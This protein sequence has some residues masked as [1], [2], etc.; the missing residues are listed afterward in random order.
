MSWCLAAPICVWA[1]VCVADALQR[2]NTY[3]LT[4]TLSDRL[5]VTFLAIDNLTYLFGPAA[6]SLAF[7][8]L[9]RP[10]ADTGIGKASTLLEKEGD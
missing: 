9:S 2:H 7:F 1:F 6:S 8:L 5:L 4:H 10:T 3:F